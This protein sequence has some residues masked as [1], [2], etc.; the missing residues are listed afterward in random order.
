MYYSIAVTREG[1]G[2]LD[3]ASRERNKARFA[4]YMNDVKEFI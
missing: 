1:R 2:G 3:L 4:T